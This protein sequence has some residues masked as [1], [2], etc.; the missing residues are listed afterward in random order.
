MEK[1]GRNSRI[2]CCEANFG[3]VDPSH[4]RSFP[5]QKLVPKCPGAYTWWGLL[6]GFYGVQ[7]WILHF[8]HYHAAVYGYRLHQMLLKI[9]RAGLNF[10]LFEHSEFIE[11]LVN[12]II[13]PLVLV[14]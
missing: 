6:S 13:S 8:F 12:K 3:S 4:G 11:I 5:F 1:R 7:F 14:G 2:S 9:L 10:R